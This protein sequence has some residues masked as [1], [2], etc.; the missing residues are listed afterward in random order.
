MGLG[1][2]EFVWN[3]AEFDVKDHAEQS[4]ASED[5]R[6]EFPIL[7]AAALLDDS[8]CG[9]RRNDSTVLL[10]GGESFCHP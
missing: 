9:Q 10:I 5:Q 6:E 2:V 8:V 3:N 1:D 4:V 7:G